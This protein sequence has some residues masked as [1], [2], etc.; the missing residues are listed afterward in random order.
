MRKLYLIIPILIFIVCSCEETISPFQ[1][2][3][4][5]KFFGSGN[6]SSGA[7][8][9]EISGEGYIFVG[10]DN[11]NQAKKQ[12]YAAKTDLNGNII[13]ENWYS[14]NDS[15][16]EGSIIKMVDSDNFIVVG[17]SKSS[18]TSVSNPFIMKIDSYG[19]VIWK[20][21]INV[22]YSL[23][24]HDFAATENSI[25]LVGESFKNSTTLSDTYIA[26][27]DLTGNIIDT[28]TTSANRTELF[29]KVFVK[30]DGKIIVLGN[31]NSNIGSNLNQLTF[32]EFQP[33]SIT[34]PIYSDPIELQNDQIFKDAIYANG[35]VSIMVYELFQ[36]SWVTS[37]I[38]INENLSLV[39]KTDPISQFEGKSMCM[40]EFGDIFIA[41][42]NNSQIQ[43]VKLSLEG[44]LYYGDEVFLKYPGTVGSL[45]NTQNNGLLMVG[46][47]PLV[48]DNMV[49][50]I[51]TGADL[52]LLKP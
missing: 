39:W 48:N 35:Q 32:N 14:S 24:I 2:K 42:D 36:G 37:I 41:G 47:T 20:K 6:G 51:K 38:K 43:F 4:F 31:S 23:F 25:F 5:I 28:V 9:L 50:L 16:Q 15:I 46:S 7:S 10:Y 13:W 33:S 44:D 3:N 18:S 30:N 22:N 8:C 52:Y 19:D 21:N 29:K 12:I 45:I 34:N 17:N 49:Q 40:N 26:K 11:N 1:S 27:V